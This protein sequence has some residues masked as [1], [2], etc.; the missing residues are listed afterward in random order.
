VSWCH[1][2]NLCLFAAGA[3]P[4]AHDAGR[5]EE[6]GRHLRERRDPRQQE[7]HQGINFEKRSFWLGCLRQINP[8]MAANV[9]RFASLSVPAHG[10]NPCPPK[11]AA[12]SS[13]FGCLKALGGKGGPGFGRA[14]TTW[15]LPLHM[16]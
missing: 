9:S 14:T 4:E 5:E 6:D 12:Q 1:R 16:G 3:E 15:V 7:R 11:L 8:V 10:R 2:R 13:L